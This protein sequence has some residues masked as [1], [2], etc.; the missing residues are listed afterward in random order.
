MAS[1]IKSAQ[2]S[3]R[4]RKVGEES[5][6]ETPTTNDI[7][8]NIKQSNTTNDSMRWEADLRASSK[9][10]EELEAALK[11]SQDKVEITQQKLL[12]LERDL[13]E[14][15]RQAED[16]GH[17]TGYEA[18][19]EEGRSLLEKKAEQLNTLINSLSNTRTDILKLAEDDIAEV[20]VSAVTKVLGDV[21]IE[22]EYVIAAIKQS[23]KQL[24]SKQNITICLSPSDKQLLDS[25]PED[26]LDK[27]IGSRVQIV[28]DE[29]IE[30]G[31]CIIHT[32]TGGLDAR[33]DVQMHRFQDCVLEIAK[34]RKLELVL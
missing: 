14:I 34:R 2:I 23:I 7:T 5:L 26:I 33:L 12:V 29:R 25:I 16:D 4:R 6:K 27:Q 24:T 30:T 18:G 1:L 3:D 17:K 8:E 15:Q 28:E 10:R 31:G 13:E 9:A 22:P 21:L 20:V 32:P 11:H 19:Y